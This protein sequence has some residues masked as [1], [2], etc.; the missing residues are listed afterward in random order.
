MTVAGNV[1]TMNERNIFGKWIV[2]L[3]SEAAKRAGNASLLN[4]TTDGVLC[5]VN[6]TS[7]P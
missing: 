6:Q 7:K 2:R 4:Q 5:E 1:Q 3:C